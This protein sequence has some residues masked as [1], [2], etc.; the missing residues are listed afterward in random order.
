[1]QARG[2]HGGLSMQAPTGGQEQQTPQ[3]TL[4][5]SED[6]YARVENR[7]LL[8]GLSAGLS[9]RSREVLRLRF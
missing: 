6:G 2:A 1:L 3:D 9:P 4:G 7:V 8:D 5:M